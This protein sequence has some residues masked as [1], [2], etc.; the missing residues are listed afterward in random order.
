MLNA[1]SVPGYTSSSPSKPDVGHQTKVLNNLDKG[2]VK[3]LE[4]AGMCSMSI[5]I[6]VRLATDL[7]DDSLILIAPAQLVNVSLATRNISAHPSN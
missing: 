2:Q 3:N 6:D 4:M 7:E 5:P 1:S